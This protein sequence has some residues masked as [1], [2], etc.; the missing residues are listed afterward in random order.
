MVPVEVISP[1]I[2]RSEDRIERL[3]LLR[4]P[5]VVGR[6]AGAAVGAAGL[7]NVVASL[8]V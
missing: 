7:E 8:G 2:L 6:V 3:L 1:T 5:P 4:L